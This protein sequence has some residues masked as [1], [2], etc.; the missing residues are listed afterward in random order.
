MRTYDGE[1]VTWASYKLDGHQLRIEID[2][3]GR[4]RAFTTRPLDVTDKIAGQAFTMGMYTRVPYGVTLL[5]ELWVPGQPASAVKTAMNARDPGLRFTCFGVEGYDFVQSAMACTAWG[6]PFVPYERVTP[7]FK[8]EPLPRLHDHPVEGWVLV[9]EDGTRYKW[10]PVRTM[11]LV[12]TGAKDGNGKYI[13]LLGALE[14]SVRLPDGSSRVVASVSGMSDAE[15]IM[16]S[17]DPPVGRVAEVAYQYVGAGG[18]LRHPRFVRL[19]DDKQPSQCG[20]GQD[21]QLDSYMEDA[22]HEVP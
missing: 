18:K 3:T 6:V 8:F 9:A 4:L 21:P 1:P 19:R 14:C 11:D 7:G 12:V 22:G 13:G 16:M 2:G 20:L 15:R 10:K 17:D 5:G